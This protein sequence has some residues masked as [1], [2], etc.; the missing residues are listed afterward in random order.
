VS[1]RKRFGGVVVVPLPVDPPPERASYFVLTR[2]IR[3]F[4]DGLYRVE[5][6]DVDDRYSNLLVSP[7]R[8]VKRLGK[9]NAAALTSQAQA[10]VVGTRAL[11]EPAQREF[12]RFE[13]AEHF[14][15]YTLYL[16]RKP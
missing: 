2:G 5:Q 9:R 14:G 15:R 11:P 1:K 8:P 16:R 10:V 6:L 4:P 13:R 7:P 12:E 3:E